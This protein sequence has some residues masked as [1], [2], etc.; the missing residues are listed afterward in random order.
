MKIMAVSQ[1]SA[2]VAKSN[3]NQ[4]G[5]ELPTLTG[6]RF[7]VASL[8]FV[9]HF[10]YLPGM[11][12]LPSHAI[13]RL[14]NYGVAIFFVLSGFILTYNYATTFQ[15]GVTVASYG[16]FIWDRLA[17]IYPLYLLTL[18]LCIP[19][20]LAGYKRI[21]SWDALGLQLTLTQCIIPVHHLDFTNYFNV[22]GWSISCE[23]LFYLLAP[24]LI[25]HCLAFKRRRNLIVFVSLAAVVM[26]GFF[27]MIAANFNWPTRFAPLRVPEFLVGVAT[28]G[29]Y[30]KAHAIGSR[31]RGILALIGLVLLA[32][33]VLCNPWVPR[34]LGSGPLAAL[35]AA[36]LIYG[37]ADAQGCVA[38]LLSNRLIVLLGMSSFAFYLIHDPLLRICKGLCQY[39]QFT[40]SQ[41][42]EMII[43][44]IILFVLTQALSVWVFKNLELPTH[45][46]LRKLT[47][48][49]PPKL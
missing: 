37:L 1:H 9:Q 19:I 6:I 16:R 20:Q 30:L 45:K 27:S 28:A 12:A 48:K 7:F 33:A 13:F 49:P 15:C 29:C 18:L 43:V 26:V 34:S 24:F 39:Y 3:Q 42:W 11:E 25:W 4:K 22:P 47:R 35:G 40:I 41:P 17:K 5:P 23:M 14:G 2:P 31:A 21:W 46:Y 44:G 32:L 38:R 8:V 10:S 36:F